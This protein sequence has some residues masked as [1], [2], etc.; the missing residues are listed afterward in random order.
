MKLH[1][2]NRQHH[3]EFFL[4]L[5][6]AFLWNQSVYCGARWIATSWNHYDMTTSFDLLV[7]F[8]PWTI[9]I[10]WGCY[11]FWCINY[12]LCAL[13]PKEER[14]RFFCADALAKGICFLFFLLIPT[15][16]IRPII[17][18]E[19]IWD[20]LMKLLYR[21][22]AADN[23]FPSIHC[24]V[25]WLCWVGLRQRK[26]IP[27]IYR[28]FSLVAA[29][30]VCISTLTT[31]QHVILDVAG[32]IFLAEVCYYLAGFSKLRIIYAFIIS[33]LTKHIKA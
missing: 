16:N 15:T 13:Q 32:G 5:L 6:F 33:S 19:T 7:P 2:K 3:T 24:L 4:V 1:P 9:I 22:D 29:I 8:M 26:D 12:Y 18:E 17:G 23:L 27:L 21:I 30:A 20:T 25:S 14:D 11:I 31:R 10:Y 28:H